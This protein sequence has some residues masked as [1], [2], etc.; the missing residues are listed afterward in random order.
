MGV[1]LWKAKISWAGSQICDVE[2]EHIG[3]WFC[4]ATVTFISVKKTWGDPQIA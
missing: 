1:F 4:D 3:M 2:Q